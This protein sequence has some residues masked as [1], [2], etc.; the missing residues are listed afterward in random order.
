[1]VFSMDKVTSSC[2]VHIVAAVSNGPHVRGVGLDPAVWERSS[3][4]R[5]LAAKPR[6]T[7][8][9]PATGDRTNEIRAA[10]PRETA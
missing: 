5:V 10:D 6:C 2:T 8:C 3:A 7:R 1:M 4:A 9:W